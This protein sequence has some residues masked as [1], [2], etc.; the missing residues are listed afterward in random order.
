MKKPKKQKCENCGE[1]IPKGMEK[2]V[3]CKIV[4]ER[5]YYK[6]KQ[7]SKR[8]LASGRNFLNDYLSWWGIKK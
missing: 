5:C 8:S 1:P 2:Y 6:L 4:C 7:P 3:K